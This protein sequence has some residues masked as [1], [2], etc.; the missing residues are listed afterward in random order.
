MAVSD[1]DGCWVHDEHEE[2][3]WMCRHDGNRCNDGRAD[4]CHDYRDG[5]ECCHSCGK[6]NKGTPLVTRAAQDL[7]N[8]TP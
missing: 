2:S 1:R 6:P 8:S 3:C 5:A 7:H 4:E